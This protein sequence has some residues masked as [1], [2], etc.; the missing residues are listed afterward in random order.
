MHCSCFQA[1]NNG[2]CSLQHVLSMLISE[3]IL[4]TFLI[5]SVVDGGLYPV[6]IGH[7]NK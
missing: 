1:E 3:G 5:P 6:G 7:I 4:R 2:M